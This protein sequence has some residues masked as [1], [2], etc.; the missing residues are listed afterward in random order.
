MNRPNVSYLLWLVVPVIALAPRP[1]T[2]QVRGTIFGPGVRQYPIAVAAMKNLTPPRIG[3]EL[4]ALIG[5]VL[6]R[7]LQLAGMFRVI[8]RDAHIESV[9]RSGVTVE[10]TNFDNW[11]VIGALALVKGSV[12]ADG[13]DLVV[14]L[15]L[16]DVAQRSMLMGKR[17]R[18]RSDDVRRM[19]HRFADEILK[20]FTGQRGPF[21]S[22][23][24]FLSTRGGRFKDVYIM[25]VDGG[26][27]K[28][29]TDENTLNLSP[30][31]SPDG[32]V[33][34]L[35]SYRLGNPDL[36]SIDVASGAW[37]RLSH[38]RGLNL[39]GR[40]SPSGDRLAV[41]IEF[42]GNSEVAILH[43]DGTLQ[44]RLTDHWAIDVSPTWAPGGDRLAFCSNRSGSPQI[45]VVD[46]A[47][48][49]PRRVTREGSYNTSPAWSPKGDVV[50]YTSRVNG[51][52]QIFT[53]TLDGT[54]V[55]QVTS[56]AGDNEDPSWAPDGR[57]LVFTS[58]RAGAPRLYV[59]DREG[60]HQVE[61]TGGKGGDTSP[62]WSRWRD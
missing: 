48:G 30:S 38:L 50:A 54:G 62:S 25:S 12:A 28:R 18:G 20:Q 10:S 1:A 22:Q 37:K 36:F 44:R 17:Y 21:D 41:T 4:T 49:E 33:I 29:L 45:Y 35:T 2:A 53:V 57:Y 61:L 59:G 56:S 43:D 14:E 27:T 19:A 31:W 47:G 52:F 24:A 9:E 26:D 60:R 55:T 34:A 15:R 39:G 6:T 58:T 23:I 3:G 8:P 40:W 32:R 46:A 5:D 11:S 16:F 7:D 13:N 51:R 42:D